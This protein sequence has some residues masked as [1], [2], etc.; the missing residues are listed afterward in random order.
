[1]RRLKTHGLEPALR[2]GL[3]EIIG[4]IQPEA[5]LF[6]LE[7]RRRGRWPPPSACMTAILPACSRS[8][9]APRE[10]GKGHG[11]RVVLSALKWA[12]LRGARQAW[13]QVEADNLAAR[14]LYETIGFTEVY[15][16]HYRRPAG[17][18]TWR[19]A[20]RR[21]C[22]WSPP[23]ALVDADGRVLIAQR[24]EGKTLA[25]LWEFPGGKVEPGETP[26]ETL[27][28]ELQARNS[29]SRPRSPA[30]RR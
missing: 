7:E 23:C 16:Y 29:A 6:V 19:T 15:R 28:R 14:R 10:R 17:G 20:N 26:E 27:V 2:P 22:C 24:P 4:A 25:G 5:G 18:L 13:L 30:S 8:P 9:P 21:S 11:R 3:S 1:M 12:R